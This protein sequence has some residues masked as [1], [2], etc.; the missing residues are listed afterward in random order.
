MV[1]DGYYFCCVY[2]LLLTGES[3]AEGVG[4]LVIRDEL[5]EEVEHV[6][7]GPRQRR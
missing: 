1:L 7:Q 4:Q 6:T 3:L 5:A 2:H